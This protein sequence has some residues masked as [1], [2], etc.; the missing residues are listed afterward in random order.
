MFVYCVIFGYIIKLVTKDFFKRN[1]F[2]D[3]YVLF[4]IFPSNF[5]NVGLNESVSFCWFILLRLHLI[6]ENF[7]HCTV[8]LWESH[9]RTKGGKA[10]GRGRIRCYRGIEWILQQCNR[11]SI[12]TQKKF[13]PD[14]FIVFFFSPFGF[15][16][17][18]SFRFGN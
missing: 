5:I 2:W 15:L 1:Q 18:L 4:T 13:T 3:F 6:S 17:I 16:S 11:F 7:H 9:V 12:Y 14:L 8:F 10:V